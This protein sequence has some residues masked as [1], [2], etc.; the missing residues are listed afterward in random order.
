MEQVVRYIFFAK[1]NTASTLNPHYSVEVETYICASRNGLMITFDNTE[2][3]FSNRSDKEL[4]R[5]HFLFRFV[6]KPIF[7]K[8]GKVALNAAFALRLPIN[9]IIRSTVFAHFCGGENV[10][11]CLPTIDRLN[12]SGIKTLL[13]YSVEGKEE[14]N[15]FENAAR[16]T[17]R[18]IEMAADDERLPFAVF[19]PTGLIR[20]GLMAKLNVGTQLT[21][22]EK[23]EWKRA[24]KRVKNICQ[25]G[26]EKGVFI[27]ID[28]EETWIQ[29]TIDSLVEEMMQLFNKEKVV[30]YNT[31]QLYRKDRLHFLKKSYEHSKQKGYKL[32]VKLVRGAYMENERK[33][34]KQQG[35]PS[36]IQNT[37]ADTDRDYNLALDFCL[38]NHPH[39]HVFAGTHNEASSKHLADEMTTKGIASSDETFRFSQLYGMSD[40]ISYNLANAGFNVVKYV[41]YGPIKEV[42][43]YLIRRAEENTSMAGQTGRELTLIEKEK[44][45]RKHL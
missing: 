13:D 35:Y 45:R 20:M 38:K 2:I 34:A 33:R 26:L 9:K 44:A 39:I 19:K 42:M 22:A 28:A 24:K 40:N 10:Q 31:I 27:L 30:V 23:A 12:R 25:I 15:D 32:G 14:E 8:V 3:A 29:N 17:L 36:P 18:T 7:V 11:D 41:P 6:G 37:K 1:K 21:E 5:A 16:E 4:E 43:P